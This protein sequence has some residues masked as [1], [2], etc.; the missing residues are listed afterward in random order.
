MNL[1]TDIDLLRRKCLPVKTIAEGLKIGRQLFNFVD[2]LN[3]VE[4]ANAV[5]LAAPQVGILKRV[6]II[7]VPALYA[8]I[9]GYRQ[10]VMINPTIV[11][12]SQ[13]KFETK[14]KC[15]SLPGLNLTT[16]RYVWVIISCDNWAQPKKFEAK[17]ND[18]LLCVAVQHEIGHLFGELIIDLTKE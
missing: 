16:F 5:G 8:G 6:A 7:Q 18:E 13:V 11:E 17:P 10:L 2:Y 14:E 3:K 4:K 15:L 9:H 12:H 1:I